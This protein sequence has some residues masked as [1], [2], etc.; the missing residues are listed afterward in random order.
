MLFDNLAGY[1][2]ESL[3]GSI[4]TADR[5][6]KDLRGIT[7]KKPTEIFVIVNPSKTGDVFS[8]TVS[9]RGLNRTI[10]KSDYTKE[11]RNHCQ[12]GFCVKVRLQFVTPVIGFNVVAMR[13]T[14]GKV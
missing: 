9:M 10:I 8:T 3:H 5:G 14:N 2:V 13:R 7:L 4:K 11:Y 1:P 6:N 12:N